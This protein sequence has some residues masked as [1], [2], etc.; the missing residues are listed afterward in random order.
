MI[1]ATISGRQDEAE[2]TSAIQNAQAQIQQIV[3][4]V[5]SGYYANNAN[6]TCT[7]SGGSLSFS[8]GTNTLGTNQGCVFLGKLIQ[9]QVHPYASDQ[10]ELD[11][12][13]AVAGAQ[14][15]SQSAFGASCGGVDKPFQNVSPT[16]VGL[17]GG[18]YGNND[19]NLTPY[20]TAINL[21]YGLNTAWVHA[22]GSDIG[23]VAIL[24]EPGGINSNNT[25]YNSGKQQVDVIPIAGTLPNQA[26]HVVAAAAN[27]VMGNA[28]L[29]LGSA[30][31]QAGVQVCLASGSTNQ[32]GLITIGAVGTQLQ[33]SLQIRD[34]L[35]C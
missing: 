31:P 24:M 25:G 3:D 4:Q 27:G 6:F 11:Q 32:S 15:D 30:N 33:V 35:T 18:S 34:G 20:S 21:Q 19:N 1:A 13:Y 22:N 17:G 28:S 12:I 9:F 5:G 7:N 26:M 23:A 16:V 8:N 29:A 2:F 14:C 10:P